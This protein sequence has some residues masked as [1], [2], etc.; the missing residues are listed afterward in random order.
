MNILIFNR[1]RLTIR[2]FREWIG[3]D[4]RIVL[5]TDA[6]A[7]SA[8]SEVRAAQLASYDEVIAVEKFHDNPLVER[9]AIGLHE[10]YGFDQI[11]AMAEFDLI[12]AARLRAVLGLP[13]QTPASA[14]VF[15]DKLL[16]KQTLAGAGIPVADYAAAPDPTSLL[17][18][19]G[20]R[21]F[22]VVLKPRRGGGSMGVRVVETEDELWDHLAETPGM[23]GDDGAATLAEEYLDH[24]LFHVDGVVVD[25][26][27]LL[28]WP[29][30]Q[31]TASCLGMIES[32]PLSSSMLDADDPL[33][34]PLRELT[35]RALAAL[36]TPA[37][38]VF[39]AEIFGTADR[40]LVFNEVACRVAGGRI[41][42]QV[43]TGF[44]VSLVELYVRALAG[45]AL[46]DVPAVPY[47]IGG[48]ALFPPRPGRL[49]AL[50]ERC[51][52]PGI[53][54]FTVHA[55]VGADLRQPKASVDSYVSAL[56][57]GDTRADVQR[58]LAALA[59][60]VA[61]ETVIEPDDARGADST[62]E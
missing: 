10:R 18:F 46:P 35:L 8:D 15:R 13:G 50:P 57:A 55:A 4:H 1:S 49:T 54:D 41:E 6:A 59:S 45:R 12:R 29:S 17:E 61:A 28:L 40:G 42:E 20:K 36:P 33:H 37:I 25:G 9:T 56:A 26:E 3:P 52:V 24:E 62:T 31:G 47:R 43:K 44:G 38:T 51:S 21:G 23:G 60:W 32:K 53:I 11:I 30:T 22:P 39:H 58:S 2:P 16:M 7:I 14:E 34:E 48:L 27:P 19:V 5:L